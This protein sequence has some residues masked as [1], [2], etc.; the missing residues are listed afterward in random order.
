MIL[1]NLSIGE[2][3]INSCNTPQNS[4]RIWGQ[5]SSQAPGNKNNDLQ[6]LPSN[7]NKKACIR[8]SAL[9][10]LNAKWCSKSKCG[11]KQLEDIVC[12]KCNL[13][14]E[15]CASDDTRCTGCGAK[16]QFTPPR[17]SGKQLI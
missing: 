13:I 7:Q 6:F 4:N 17:P 10:N 3:D 14:N 15:D 8:C 5:L 9:L 12:Q 1:D 11:I 2:D 16:I